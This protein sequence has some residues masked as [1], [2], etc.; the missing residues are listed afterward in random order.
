MP[1]LL[2]GERLKHLRTCLG[3]TTRDVSGLSQRIAETEGSAEFQISNS[4][5]TQLENSD[6]VPSIYKLFSLSSIYGVKFTDLLAMCGVDLDRLVRHQVTIALPRTHLIS[7]P[8]CDPEKLVSFPVEFDRS[9]DA[10]HTNLVSRVVKAWQGIPSAVVQHLDMRQ[11]L[12]GVIGLQD[13]TM[14]PLVCPGSLVQIDPRVRTV[15][16]HGWR[17]E[18]DRP[19]Y[20]VRLREGY[21]CCWC[22][23]QLEHL[24]MLPHPLSPCGV[25][26]LSRQDVEI[27][28]QVTATV[29]PLMAPRA[30]QN[31]Q[32]GEDETDGY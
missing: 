24:L 28:G 23:L 4:W 29:M 3:I 27:V 26:R 13:F 9:F 31:R 12:Y 14:V 6:S 30:I 15:R 18:Y 25:K 1:S 11:S 16:S 32:T 8:A 17:T 7:I 19:I 20:F 2:L 5:L 10:N 21:S 22:E